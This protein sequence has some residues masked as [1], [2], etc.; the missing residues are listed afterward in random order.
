M[1]D[2]FQELAERDA[3]IHR[4]SGTMPTAND[5]SLTPETRLQV[6]NDVRQFL[7][8][9]G[10]TQ[11]DLARGIR[12]VHESDLSQA[13][14]LGTT[15]K[16]GKRDAILRK[17]ANWIELEYRAHT[18]REQLPATYW[19]TRVAKRLF[20]I[21]RKLTERADMGVAY[22][23]A[24]IG[25]STIA[26]AIHL[27][28]PN[29][30]LMTVR[31]NTRCRGTFLRALFNALCYRRGR[32]NSRVT[33]DEVVERL[34]QSSRVASRPLL[35]IDQ[36]HKLHDAVLGNILPDLHDECGVS[37]LL[38]GTVSA[39]KR[40]T[41]DDDIQF[42]QLSSRVGLRCNLAPE[43]FEAAGRTQTR[44]L[45]TVNDIRKI[46]QQGKVRLHA[47][48][49]D[50][51]CRTANTSIGHLRRVDRLVQWGSAFARKRYN[52]GPASTVTVL[53]VDVYEASRVVEGDD[54][55]Q[56]MPAEVGQVAAG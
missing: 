11:A 45:F 49:V 26:K 33:F 37:I 24:G 54:L 23:P 16:A 43:V 35:I 56:A 38:V 28:L 44:K 52:A 25:K 22:G 42:G 4:V 48:A 46:F 30:I 17:A 53:A 7:A 51:L 31:D 20:A 8:E 6:M 41:D 39:H 15:M 55:R 2:F 34:K 50:L 32:R 12:G 13:L 27:E 47:D 18:S 5:G 40:I 1:G 21:A 9:F 36:A 29:A 3:R 19:E 14:T 10:L